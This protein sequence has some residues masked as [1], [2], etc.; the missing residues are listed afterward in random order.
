MAKKQT[1]KIAAYN[2][3]KK[4]AISL[5]EMEREEALR[6]SWRTISEMNTHPSDGR[7]LG[8]GYASF[9]GGS[10]KNPYGDGREE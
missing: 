2:G 3:C 1:K 8:W 5:Y 10:K 7:C 4:E 9:Y 6:S